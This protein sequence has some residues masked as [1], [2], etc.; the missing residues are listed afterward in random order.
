MP[1]SPYN[2]VHIESFARIFL[3]T[4]GPIWCRYGRSVFR[5]ELDWLQID[6][7]SQQLNYLKNVGARLTFH[8]VYNR[9]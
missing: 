7:D 8:W 6:G 9:D 2:A 4:A 5:Q 3:E 1:S